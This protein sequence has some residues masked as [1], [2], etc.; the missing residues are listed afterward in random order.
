MSNPYETRLENK[1]GILAAMRLP[2]FK[3]RRYLSGIDWLIG[4]MDHH[5]RMSTS[6]G[7]HS[8]LIVELSSAISAE[9][10]RERLA[11]LHERLPELTGRV[12]RDIFNLAPYWKTAKSAPPPPVK[13]VDVPDQAAFRGLLDK[14]LN[15]PF[16]D[17]RGH[18]RFLIAKREYAGDALLMTFDH[19]LLDARGAELF[20]N[21]LSGDELTALESATAASVPS[22]PELHHWTAQFEAGRAVQRKLIAAS[23]EECFGAKHAEVTAGEQQPESTLHAEF[24]KFNPDTTEK[25]SLAAE[26]HAGFMMQTPFLLALAATAFQ[27]AAAPGKQIKLFVPVPIDTR[28][29]SP[30]PEILLFNHISFVFF[31]FDVGPDI[32]LE[33]VCRE[34]RG[35]LMGAMAE[36][37]PSA[38]E[39]GTRP[40][41]IFPRPLLARAMNLPFNGDVCSLAFANVG[42]CSGPGEILSVPV[43]SVRH[44][45]RTPS[46]PGIGVFF[47]HDSGSLRATIT[48]DSKM[49][50]TDFPGKML[51]SLRRTIDDTLHII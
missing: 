34:I 4:A 43:E 48:A 20:L 37:F 7:N 19:K 46:P 18:I 36:E 2:Y 41:R 50:G 42:K 25:I 22:S 3:N 45:P 13:Q 49:F 44:M 8:T 40:L 29:R 31:H 14:T 38:M 15:R 35:Q 26:K 16:K 17:R 28:P 1:P 39:L 32:P 33:K 9:A 47:N 12:A 23:K 51:D 21:L 30:A 6:V 10:L 24:A 11:S 5:S 27:R